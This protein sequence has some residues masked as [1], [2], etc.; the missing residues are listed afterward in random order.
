MS[1]PCPARS[2]RDQATSLPTR[3]K[4]LSLDLADVADVLDK[5]H[6]VV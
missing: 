6:A 2:G 4:L 1:G 5:E 3:E